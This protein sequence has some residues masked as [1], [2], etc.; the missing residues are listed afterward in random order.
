M[1]TFRN[2]G[3][4]AVIYTGSE[5][6]GIIIFDPGKDVKL[7]HWVPYKRLGLRLV[8]ES[9][10]PVP[11]PVLISGEF[12]FTPG[13]KRRYEI[14][15]CKTYTLDINVETGRVILYLGAS[16][17]GKQISLA[18]YHETLEWQYAP[19]ITLVGAAEDTTVDVQATMKE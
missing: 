7:S 8:N 12:K 3:E 1:P 6:K 10:P 5:G 14:E 17:N 16:K 15:P 11:T 19:Y 2:D 13:M 4:R 9:Y 18:E